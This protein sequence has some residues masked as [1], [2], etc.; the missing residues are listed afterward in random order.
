MRTL[1]CLALAAVV[2]VLSQNA[3]ASCI[4]VALLDEYGAVIKPDGLV[5]GIKV[6]D[7]P[8]FV[9][10]LPSHRERREVFPT[11]C[12]PEVIKS[13]Q[14]LYNLSCQSEQAMQQAA[15]SNSTTVD[16][17]RQRCGDLTA[18][19]TSAGGN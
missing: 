1:Y 14:D 12:P 17:V 9:N 10:E 2:C 18:A 19:L 4:T 13:I 16:L 8:V 6:V 7:E 3:S 15:E 11:A 5:I